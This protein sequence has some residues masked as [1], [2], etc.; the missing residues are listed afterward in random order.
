MRTSS[1]KSGAVWTGAALLLIAGAIASQLDAQSAISTDGVV[2]STSGGFKFPDGTVQTTASEIVDP[3]ANPHDPAD[4]MILVGAVC[5]DKYEA[6]VWSQPNGG[7]QYGVDSDDYPC[8]NNGQDCDNI[9]ARSVAGVTPSRFINW[10]QA[11]RALANAGKRLPTNAEW[12]MAVSGT[13]DPGTG[14]GS[15]DCHLNNFPAGP[16]ETGERANCV[17]A[18]G[19]HDMIGNLNEWVADWGDEAADCANWVNS[20]FG[21]DES[22]VG[23]GDGEPN[24]HFPGAAIRG[25]FWNGGA[26]AGPFAVDFVRPTGAGHAAGFRGAR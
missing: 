2:E 16:E 11:Q 17:S 12:Q 14:G 6:S 25:G 10:F 18:F 9:F 4:K 1:S 13:P 26:G 22:C 19:H 24:S 8:S 7:T 5:I 3:C 15:E 20:G 21:T 23:L